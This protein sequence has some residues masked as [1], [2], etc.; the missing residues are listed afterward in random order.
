MGLKFLADHCVST[1]IIEALRHMGQEV[2]RLR[3]L[4]PPDSPD[5]AVITKAKDTDAIL[6]SL[7]GDFTDIVAYPPDAYNGIIA[8]QVRNHPEAIHELMERLRVYLR[9][10]PDSSHYKG[11]LL[12]VEVHRVRIRG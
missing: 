2:I 3:D 8:L 5:I 4:M 12:V 1:E 11:K 7:N 10:F 6:I 9:S